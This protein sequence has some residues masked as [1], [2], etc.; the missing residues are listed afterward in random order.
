MSDGNSYERQYALKASNGLVC[1]MINA[2]LLKPENIEQAFHIEETY[3][4]RILERITTGID[5]ASGTQSGYSTPSAPTND[6]EVV[7]RLKDGSEKTKTYKDH[8]KELGFWWNNPKGSYD[9][10]KKMKQSEWNSL[11]T[12][13]PF[14]DFKAVVE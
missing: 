5:T 14:K 4:K 9:W 11:K 6:K 2:G 1:S 10:S 7:V 8:I 12:Q 13:S 3:Y